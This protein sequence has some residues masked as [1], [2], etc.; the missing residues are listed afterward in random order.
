VVAVAKVRKKEVGAVVKTESKLLPTK[1]LREHLIYQL[2]ICFKSNFCPVQSKKSFFLILLREPL[3]ID[4]ST[5]VIPLLDRG[6][7]KNQ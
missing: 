3:K 6:I 2:V 1:I 5:V 4:F 7:Q